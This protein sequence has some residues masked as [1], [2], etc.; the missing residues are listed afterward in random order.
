MI[1]GLSGY[2]RSGKDTVANYLIE[3]HGF[4]RLAFADPMR[5]ALYALN[6]SLG[7]SRL[8]LQEVIDEYSWD[9]Y[10]D[11]LFGEEIRGLLQRMGTEVGRDMFGEHFWVDYLL[12]KALEVSGNVVISDVRFLNEANAIHQANGQVW[13]VNRPGIEAANSHASELQMDSFNN[14]DVVITNDTTIEELFLE[15]TGLMDR[16]TSHNG[17]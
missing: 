12:N 5:E 9:G 6:P 2:A 1:I 7:L 13:R 15:L 11:T 16:I 4:T 14:F 10:K 17:N 3:N 8:S